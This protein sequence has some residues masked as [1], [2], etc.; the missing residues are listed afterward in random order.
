MSFNIGSSPQYNR[1]GSGGGGGGNRRGSGGGGGG[2]SGGGNRSMQTNPEDDVKS[3][4]TSL[5]VRIGDKSTTALNSNIEGLVGVLLPDLS[6]NSSTIQNILF[7]CISQLPYK[8]PIYATIVGK[9]NLKNHEFGKEI[10]C[11][12][13][14]EL[15]DALAKQKFAS[16]K[17][18]IRFI[19]CLIATNVLL[20]SAI[21]EVFETLMSVLT[22]PQ[23]TQAK[24]DFYIYLVMTTIPWVAQ[25][26]QPTHQQQLDTVLEELETYLASRSVT[27][28]KFFQSFTENDDRLE[29]LMKQIKTQ[30][31]NNWNCDS[32]IQIN[33]SFDFTEA[34]QHV[35]TPINI[36]TE[37]SNFNYPLYTNPVFR[38]FDDG[39]DGQLKPIDRHV[40]EEYI[41]DI[42][43]FFNGSHKEAA[44]FIYSLPVQTEI[45]HI[46]VETI[47]A[48]AFKLPHSSF[49]SI[50]YSVMF[51]DLFR[52]QHATI[53]P[54]F[55][56]AINML[57]ENIDQM[58]TEIVSRFSL[59]FAHHL[60]N[61]EFKWVWSDWSVPLTAA[62]GENGGEN[63][64]L[65]LL[66]HE[67]SKDL[68]SQSH[69]L[70]LSFK[71]K[72]PIEN[73]IQ[74]VAAI[75]ENINVV[76][77]V[78]KCILHIG[79]T[80]FSHLTYAIERY[81]TLFK[82]TIKSNED[83][84][85]CLKSTL[86]FWQSSHQHV[87]IVV[88][89]LI[90]YKILAPIDPIAML[91][92]GDPKNGVVVTDAYVWEIIYN[93]IEKTNIIID[94]LAKDYEVSMNSAEKELKLKSAQ[95]EQQ[96]LFTTMFKSLDAL[97]KNPH[98]DPV[99]TK[100]LSGHLK[101]TA[102]RYLNQLKPLFETN[103]EILEIVKQFTQ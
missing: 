72:E 19:A 86:Q 50:Y 64:M 95:T 17:L 74:Q 85:E 28:K 91:L 79:S 12:L 26:I 2:G 27:E 37:D 100:I 30:K 6:K 16:A 7:K 49:K 76:E 66:Q 59:M 47:L 73:I 45:D 5:I 55:A 101:S 60:S 42:L 87:V 88:D 57:Y 36:P 69:K 75:P 35:L 4:L 99:S 40:I 63:D 1:R 61:Y 67:E 18:L 39:T 3:K 65:I 23:F 68:V 9:M 29:L 89:K 93:S 77:L 98:I 51:V 84:F 34:N 78:T 103:T 97:L 62:L 58:D 33:K 31:E 70:L 82:T 10:V 46:V 94:T 48:E 22:L 38:L 81:V 24:S 43:Y 90:T 8:T 25:Y 41:V 44:K 32:I 54:V 83:R 11:T 52:D 15:N 21:F 92:S 20:P 102:R 80:S 96:T 14:D 71:Q 56:Y 53:I 13:V